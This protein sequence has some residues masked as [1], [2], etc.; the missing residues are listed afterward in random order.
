MTHFHSS[1]KGLETLEAGTISFLFAVKS[2]ILSEADVAEFSQ[3]FGISLK[4]FGLKS[5][6]RNFFNVPF[7][8][9]ILNKIF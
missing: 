2:A 7:F 9:I 1:I 4:D 3:W 6:N 8:I 5:K